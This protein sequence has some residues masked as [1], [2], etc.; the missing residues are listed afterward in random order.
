MSFASV[1]YTITKI[2]EFTC[3]LCWKANGLFP[4]KPLHK[5]H[6]FTKLD[7]G[8]IYSFGLSWT[9]YLGSM[10]GVAFPKKKPCHTTFYH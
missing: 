9:P 6:W 7:F 8:R 10:C 3:H 1:M 4:G 5:T 2:H